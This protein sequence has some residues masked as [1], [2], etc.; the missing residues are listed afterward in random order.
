MAGCE[1][2]SKAERNL[3]GY[4]DQVQ[5]VSQQPANTLAAIDTSVQRYPGRRSI[6][7]PVTDLRINFWEALSLLKCD[8]QDLIAERNSILSKVMPVSRLLHWEHRFLI[9]ITAC[10]AELPDDQEKD[11]KLPARLDSIITIKE[12]DLSSVYWNATFASP[13]FQKLFSLAVS[14]LDP[15]ADYPVHRKVVAA[16][17][18]FSVVGRHLGRPDFDMDISEME[19]NNQAL[20]IEPYGAALLKSIQ[21]LREYLNAVALSIDAAL[22]QNPNPGPET[23]NSYFE[24]FR[25]TY[26]PTIQPYL[27]A[28][29][30]NGQE[31][32]SALNQLYESQPAS[33]PENFR[34]YYQRY[35]SMETPDGLW[36]QFE[37]AIQ[38]HNRSW[39]KLLDL[40]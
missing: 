6:Q 12:K 39:Q 30:R 18:Y 7:L 37:R 16:L 13:E 27:S 34:D 4:L 3:S 1:W 22:A 38:R 26:G 40:R 10:R 14:P 35:L 23:L 36:Q 19:N 15:A 17:E 2:T 20:Q 33:T 24:I 11:D 29:H 21:L 5:R 25:T 8:V 9:K 32:L 31:F 28:V